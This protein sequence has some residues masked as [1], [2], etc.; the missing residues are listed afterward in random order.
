MLRDKR[1]IWPAVSVGLALGLA[2]LTR[3]DLIA[4]TLLINRFRLGGDFRVLPRLTSS[5]DCRLVLAA[6]DSGTAQVDASV[7][8]SPCLA[9]DTP[10]SD[11]IR[12]RLGE[13]H[14]TRS[15]TTKAHQWWQS[16]KEL[17]LFF[18]QQAAYLIEE[19]D[20]FEA[21]RA[22]SYV[23]DWERC[24]ST[25]LHLSG[26]VALQLDDQQ[27]ALDAWRQALEQNDYC[28]ALSTTYHR[29]V[30]AYQLGR[31]AADIR[32]W[33]LALASLQLATELNPHSATAWMRLGLVFYSGF[34]D[35]E[36]AEYALRQS[37]EYGDIDWAH[38]GLG[39][40]LEAQG[41]GV[42]AMNEMVTAF[43]ISPYDSFRDELISLLDSTENR[44]AALSVSKELLYLS[45]DDPLI[46]ATNAKAAAEAGEMDKAIDLYEKALMME[47][48]VSWRRALQELSEDTA[49]E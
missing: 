42:E 33:D 20:P 34:Q 6:L 3:G 32:E 25:R 10:F 16:G 49:T 7:Q 17:D 22:L 36:K 39:R 23:E 43:R 35:L 19:G 44:Q 4:Q 14:M 24:P 41:H 37:L 21:N 15:E 31:T 47:D 13:W 2:M 46:L 29:G 8:D 1:S 38:F 45:P 28:A 12:L 9:T 5:T 48:N 30:T 18:L 11:L 27:S 40:V 26:L